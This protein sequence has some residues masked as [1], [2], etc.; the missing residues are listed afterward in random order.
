MTCLIV[1]GGGA[2]VI[3]LIQ[4]AL[5]LQKSNGISWP[6]LEGGGQ[7]PQGYAL[8]FGVGGRTGSVGAKEMILSEEQKRA[9][10][11]KKTATA[12]TA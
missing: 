12:G 10:Q 1:L 2:C 6:L 3:C 4:V 5:T 9:E 11:E 7:T 8:T